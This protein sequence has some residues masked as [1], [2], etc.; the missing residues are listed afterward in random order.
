MTQTRGY[1]T[2]HV[3]DTARGS[4]A[5]GLEIDV[6]RIDG[7]NRQVLRRMQTNDDGRCDS[8]VIQCG[9]LSIG[10]YELLF[11]GG[12]YLRSLAL[13]AAPDGFLDEVPI[14][15]WVQDADQHYHVPLLLS[16]FGYTT[17]RGS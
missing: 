5:A 6:F 3:L 4:P 7:D 14:R 1:V 9:E 13:P 11:H 10:S 12:A 17:Y 15:F 2:T 8:P 16:P